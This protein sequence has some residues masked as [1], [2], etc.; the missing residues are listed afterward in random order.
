[1]TITA[2]CLTPSMRTGFYR[3][4]I[5]TNYSMKDSLTTLDVPACDS[6]T[7][8]PP[9]QTWGH[10]PPAIDWMRSHA[11]TLLEAWM[12]TG[13]TYMALQVLKSDLQNGGAALILCPQPVIGVW[14]GETEKFLAGQLRVLALNG[15]QSAEQKA[16]LVTDAF[17]NASLTHTP[18][19]V[20]VN[21]ET[22]IRGMP[23]AGQKDR[24][25]QKMA[26]ALLACSWRVV[27]VDESQRIK[28]H[29]SQI[30]RLATKLGAQTQRRIALTGT[31]LDNSPGDAFAQLRFLDPTIFGQY[32][33]HFVGRYGVRN[34][35]IPGKIDKWINMEDFGRKL[36]RVRYHIPK[37]VLVLPERQDITVPVELS[38]A[39]KA[40]YYKMKKDNL[41]QI[42]RAIEEAGSVQN[43][44][45]TRA[46]AGN[47]AILFLR[48]LQLAQ[49]YVYAENGEAE[50]TC[51]AK[52][53]MLME[54][55]QQTDEKVCVYG[56]FKEDIRIIRTC[57]E[58]LGRRFGEIS[59]S[60]KDL[61][62]AGKFPEDIDVMA[63][64]VKSGSVGIDL[65]AARIGIILTTGFISPGSF[66]Q[67]MARQ[68]RPGQ[69]KNCV[70]YH[71]VCTGTID[72]LVIK[73]R[74]KKVAVIE[75]A[76]RG[77]VQELGY[78]S[79]S[80]PI[81]GGDGLS[82]EDAPW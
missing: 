45:W 77:A 3:N 64:Q 44:E 39:G 62:E 25:P 67:L 55:L 12:G 28:A 14:Q 79:D 75:A 66:D 34:Q 10:Q 16:Q 29:D 19:L 53:Q 18:L 23:P 52:R 51:S 40:A 35:H 78:E 17:K 69:T 73:A 43:I 21:Y 32:W 30:S 57:A 58:E 15:S 20:I 68:Y 49:G 27:I 7:S 11:A 82:W 9:V 22:A 60:R 56:Y 8:K 36:A 50:T 1:M 48:L 80:L 38:P 6:Q 33:T 26:A 13:K 37:S 74:E 54:L 41:L 76:L 2:T 65:T 71:L 70:Y 42:N 81:S 59:G 24:R 61:T 63:V 4:W 47:G 31:P 72:E 46:F 5:R